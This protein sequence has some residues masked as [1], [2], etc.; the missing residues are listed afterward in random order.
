MGIVTRF[1][2]GAMYPWAGETVTSVGTKG[3]CE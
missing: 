2:P 1:A 3:R